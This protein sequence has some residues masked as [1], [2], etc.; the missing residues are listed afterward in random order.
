MKTIK[1]KHPKSKLR[2]L[3]IIISLIALI[4]ACVT[5]ADSFQIIVYFVLY[6]I[7]IILA[8]F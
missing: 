6:A 5:Y 2:F 8:L 1:T 7:S 4:I 3:P